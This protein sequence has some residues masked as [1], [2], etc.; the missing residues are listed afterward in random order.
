MKLSHATGSHLNLKGD[1][2]MLSNLEREKMIRLLKSLSEQDKI[3]FL[4]FLISLQDPPKK[5]EPVPC[6]YPKVIQHV[7]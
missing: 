5:Q 1:V 6:H 3:K 4:D 7:V 2:A